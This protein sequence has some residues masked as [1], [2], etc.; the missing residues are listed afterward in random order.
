MKNFIGE[1]KEFI[2][3]GNVVDMAI[4]VVIGTAFGAI[5]TSLVDNIVMPLVGI[6][7]GGIDISGLAI[8][9]GGATLGYG[10]F[11]Q[12]VIDFLIVA[13]VIFCAVRAMN[14]LK[15]KL[16]KPEEEAP[17]EYTPD[18]ITL[19]TEIRDILKNK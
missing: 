16:K 12:N 14:K 19:L 18:D 17:S 2:S 5:V 1:F 11:L 8:K 9:V 3:Q 7:A 15:N 10:V 13:F 6:I 4:G